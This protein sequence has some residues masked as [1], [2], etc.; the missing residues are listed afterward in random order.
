MAATTTTTTTTATGTT[1]NHDVNPPAPSLGAEHSDYNYSLSAP[2]PSRLNTE[3]SD[4]VP[5]SHLVDDSQLAQSMSDQRPSNAF[6]QQED[7]KDDRGSSIQQLEGAG[8]HRTASSASG[9]LPTRGNTLKKKSSVSRKSS[10]KRNSSHRSVNA[11]SLKV[12]SI[13]DQRN[14]DEQNSIFYTPVPTSGSPTDILANRFQNWRKVLKELITYF[15]EVQVSYEHKA[16]A[17]LKVSNV[18][19]NL[20]APTVFTVEGGLSEANRILREY[21]RQAIT[22][23]N[24]AKDIEQDVIAQLIGLR[25]D[26]AA[27]IKE[28]KSLSGDFKN[29][30]EKEKEG[31]KRAVAALGEALNAA[32]HEPHAA[33][34]KNDPYITKLSVDRQVE[35]QIDEENY[36]HRAY[37]NLEGSGRELES[38]VVG[39]VQKAYNALAGIMKR[40][41]D[42]AHD[43]VDRLRYGP[44][45]MPKDAEWIRFIEHDPHFIAPEV[46]LRKLEDIYYP[47]KDH[48]AAAEVRAGMLE[49]KSKYLKSYTPGW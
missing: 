42:G 19:N 15:K 44:I 38:I 30:V 4:F 18:V 12:V 21:H 40:E 46:Q 29:S 47:G 37:L 45:T 35:R 13:E 8:L 34:G 32:D 5:A 36:L 43:A 33:I 25:Q 26:L 11:G 22:E 31:T 49:R 28:I 7:L 23:A 14:V 9:T 39:E 16:K 10:L 24:K 1:I 20:P 48:P 2:E 27:K 6:G 3:A 17:L 41:A